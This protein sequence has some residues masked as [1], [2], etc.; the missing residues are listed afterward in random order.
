MLSVRRVLLSRLKRSPRLSSSAVPP[1]PP[2]SDDAPPADAPPVSS[3]KHRLLCVPLST[4]QIMPVPRTSLMYLIPQQFPVAKEVVQNQAEKVALVWVDQKSSDS[5]DKFF[6]V[7]V[8]SH[9]I[10]RPSKQGNFVQL[11]ALGINRVSIVDAENT[12]FNRDIDSYPL[13]IDVEEESMDALDNAPAYKNQLVKA[14]RDLK[15]AF[16]LGDEE[17]FQVDDVLENVEDLSAPQLADILFATVSKYLTVEKCVDITQEADAKE[18][19]M[20]IIVALNLFKNVRQDFREV[21][22]ELFGNPVRADKFYQQKLVPDLQRLADTA[23]GSDSDA[24]KFQLRMLQKTVPPAVEKVFRQELSRFRQIEPHHS[25]HQTIRNYLDWITQLPWGIN[26]DDK[27]N[28]DLALQVLDDDHYGM[29]DVKKRILEFIAVGSLKGDV[30]GKILCFSGPPGVGKTSIASSIAK[31]LGRKFERIS[32]GGVDDVASIKGHRRTYVGSAPGSL[33][34]ALKRCGSSNPVILIDEIDK[35]GRTERGDPAAALL[36]ALDK[37]QNHSFLDQYIDVGVDLSKVLFL[38]TANYP[39]WIPGPLLDRM[40]VIELP[41]YVPL[42]KLEIAKRHLLPKAMKTCGLKDEHVAFE[43][44]AIE[45]LIAYY[46]R[47]PGVRSLERYIEKCLRK[48]ALKVKMSQH[49]GP[50]V[51]TPENLQEYAGLPIFSEKNVYGEQYPA[52]LVNRF[53]PSGSV[54]HVE[55]IILKKEPGKG[56]IRITGG[57]ENVV[58]EISKVSWSFCKKFLA[59]QGLHDKAAFFNDALVHMHLLGGYKK[60]NAYEGLPIVTA[61]LSLALEQ[62]ISHEI[63]LCGEVTLNG[64]VLRTQGLREKYIGA[65]RYGIKKMIVSKECEVEYDEFPKEIKG[66][67]EIKF[68]STFSEVFDEM[69]DTEIVKS[70]NQTASVSAE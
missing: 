19:M 44:F 14:A 57:A 16:N 31:A 6:K 22:H 56:E 50:L 49:S 34:A 52:G 21:S 67:I 18:R 33:I 38:A 1:P 48:V 15:H 60:S 17:N 46:C 3:S 28:P 64:K 12:F 58:Q 55:A 7:G 41:S 53:S 68:V 29:D 45:K 32:M 8:M 26:T 70:S 65:L 9:I 23:E 66:K 63:I 40:E 10:N 20:K 59:D 42:Q 25:E 11:A 30:S 2:P 4:A 61:F 13:Y 37:S 69:F 54:S 43:D 35:C 5:Q 47:E 36:E 51:I 27:L 62:P 24:S 39:H